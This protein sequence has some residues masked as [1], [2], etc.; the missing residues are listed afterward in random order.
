MRNRTL[1]VWVL[2]LGLAV[3]VVEAQNLY[4]DGNVGVGTTSPQAPL[5]VYKSTGPQIFAFNPTNASGAIAGVRFATGGSWNVQLRTRQGGA[6]LELTDGNGQVKHWWDHGTYRIGPQDGANEGG[7][8]QFVGAG[9]YNWW[10]MDNFQ[11]ALR[12]H[13]DNST[14]IFLARD[15]RLGLGTAS[16]GAKLHVNGAIRFESGT[17]SG[18]SSSVCWG[19]TNHELHLC[20][21][22]IRFKEEVATLTQA[23]ETLRQLRGVTFRWKESGQPGVGLIAEEVG[24]VIPAALT[25]GFD[26]KTPQGFDEKAVIAVL[27]EAVKAQ[28]QAIAQLERKNQELEERLARLEAVF[29]GS[30]SHELTTAVVAGGR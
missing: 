20:P 15:G 29:A 25:Y 26:G 27:V 17:G 5:H 21:S 1:V 4:V 14:H 18:T 28:D 13:H 24:Q 8:L 22:S 23:R 3:G 12:F 30:H 19:S 6:W 9:T 11:G 10:I 16:P 7:E 2:S